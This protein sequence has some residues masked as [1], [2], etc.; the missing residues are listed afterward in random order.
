MEGT[1]HVLHFPPPLPFSEYVQMPIL[2]AIDL[3]FSLNTLATFA[4]HKHL[5][6]SLPPRHRCRFDLSCRSLP[7]SLPTSYLLT[8][9]FRHC[10]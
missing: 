2:V 7:S 9:I 5:P 10:D 3:A 6:P 1:E 8:S 4:G